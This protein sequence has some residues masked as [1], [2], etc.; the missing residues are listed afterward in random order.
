VPFSTPSATQ[1]AID[2]ITPF[3]AQAKF[4]SFD[5][6]VRLASRLEADYIE[7]EATGPG[8]MLALIAAQRAANGL[9]AYAGPSDAASVLAELMLQ[10][11]FEFYLEAKRFGDFRRNGGAVPFVPAP[12]A[13]YFKPGFSA[14]GSLTCLPIPFAETSTNP[15][16]P[17]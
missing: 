7:A 10:R 14:V 6:P 11:S 4:G 17:H 16:F 13:P 1:F 12:G 5:A 2:G 9:P 8:A 15:N 3:F